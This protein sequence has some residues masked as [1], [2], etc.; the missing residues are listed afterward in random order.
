MSVSFWPAD[1]DGRPLQRCTC[2]DFSCTACDLTLNVSNVNACELFAHI[3]LAWEP[4]GTM[5]AA[6]FAAMCER[7]LARLSAEPMIPPRTEGRVVW[8]GRRAGYLRDRTAELLRV[9][10]AAGNG[11]VAWA[12]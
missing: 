3:G 1:L 7:R 12:D 4:V 5:P 6:E 8:C 11:F 9:A 10:L 2:L